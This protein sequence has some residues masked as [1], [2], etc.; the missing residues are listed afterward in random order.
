M[1][2]T[3]R[4]ILVT[5]SNTGVGYELVRFLA[6]RG[7]TVYLSGRD[8]VLVQDAAKRL[9]EEHNLTVKFLHLDVTKEESVNAAKAVIE[10]AE[11]R[12]DV[13]VNNAAIFPGFYAPSELPAEILAKTL[14]VNYVGVVRVT[15]AFL[16]LIRKSL[17]K[18]VILNVSSGS[19][20]HYYQSNFPERYSHQV[21]AYY[22]SK[23]ALNAYTISLAKELK[24]SGIRVN[25]ATPGL[26]KTQFNGFLEGARPVTEGAETI[27]PWAILDDE[28]DRTGKF[29]GYNNDEGRIVDEI[30]W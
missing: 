20:S 13:L 19:G 23:A 7:H 4:I 29:G 24:E 16:P 30:R 27:L 10:K 8:E 15:T 11:G 26:T 5:G 21:A 12:L 28:D 25:S 3:S 2:P 6:D 9:K 17:G 18:G 14:D 22:G 1:A